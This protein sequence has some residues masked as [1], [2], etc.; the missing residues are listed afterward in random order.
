M[1]DVLS[2]DWKQN[3]NAEDCFLRVK[4]NA[5]PGSII[6]F[7]DSLKAEKRML[8]ALEKTLKY[9]SEKGFRFEGLPCKA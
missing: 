1:W 4:R 7:H 3:L 9:F 5:K 6:V 8:P 2:E